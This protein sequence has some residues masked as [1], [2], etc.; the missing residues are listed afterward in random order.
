MRKGISGVVA[1]SW[2]SHSCRRCSSDVPGCLS[3]L[4]CR[5]VT[6]H[7]TP[8]SLLSREDRLAGFSGSRCWRKGLHFMWGLCELWW[9]DDCLF[10]TT[11]FISFLPL[12]PPTPLLP[13][14]PPPFPWLTAH[15]Q[16]T[17]CWQWGGE[18]DPDK[19]TFPF[20]VE[21]P[22]T[23]CPFVGWYVCTRLNCSSPPWLKVYWK[24]CCLSL[25]SFLI[26]NF[27]LK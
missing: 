7:D 15:H 22:N 14:Q 4:L 18:L 23:R 1:F 19:V 9:M 11:T 2:V 10:R 16:L 3:L 13:L 17:T 25:C 24:H 8:V 26:S 21:C 6:I 5:V 20:P 27:V 12:N